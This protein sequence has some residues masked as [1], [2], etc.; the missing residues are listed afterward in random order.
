MP[1]TPPIVRLGHP[2]R[3]TARR[4]ETIRLAATGSR[5]PDGDRLEYR[6]FHYPEPGTFT[7]SS[8]K[9]G[10]PIEIATDAAG[11]ADVT[12]P[13]TRVLRNG[14]LHLILEVTDSGSPRLTR[15]RR[16]IVNVTD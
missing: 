2:D 9:V 7:V 5:D 8:G 16:V 1:T 15:Y 4:G 11:S 6:W 13:T 12:I 14:T 3:L 10:V